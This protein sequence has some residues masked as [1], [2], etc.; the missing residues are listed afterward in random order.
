[1]GWQCAMNNESQHVVVVVIFIIAASEVQSG[2]AVGSCPASSAKR[3][4]SAR[5]PSGRTKGKGHGKMLSG[6]LW[7][8]WRLP[9]LPALL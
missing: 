6:H 9:L 2:Q 1:M 5:S 3:G 4:L 7:L 8:T